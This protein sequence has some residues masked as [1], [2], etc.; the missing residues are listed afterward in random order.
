[1]EV[2]FQFRKSADSLTLEMER[3][4][5]GECWVEFSPA[6]SLRT[7]VVSVEMDGKSIPFKVQPNKNDQ[8]PYI[9]FQVKGAESRVVVRLKDDFGLAF[10]NDLPPLGSVSRGLRVISETWNAARTEFSVD[11]SGVA[12]KAYELDVWN[13]GQISLVEGA[14]LTKAGKLRVQMMP[15][16]PDS[17]VPQKITLHFARQ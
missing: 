7:K 3:S 1:V 4:G 11:V 9:R 13:P 16:A 14:T 15:G 8:H 6:L 2:D 17:Y 10:D 12:G 5:P